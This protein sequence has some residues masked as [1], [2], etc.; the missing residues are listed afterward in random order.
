MSPSKFSNQKNAQCSVEKLNDP[1]LVVVAFALLIGASLTGS[2]SL[3][4]LSGSESR[5]SF[6]KFLPISDKISQ[7]VGYLLDT[8]YFCPAMLYYVTYLAFFTIFGIK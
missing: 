3:A 7:F 1:Y 4:G 5:E 2:Y 8:V 6:C